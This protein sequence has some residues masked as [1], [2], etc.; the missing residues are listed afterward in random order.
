MGGATSP[1]DESF[2][3]EEKGA[4]REVLCYLEVD[5]LGGQADIQCHVR[6]FKHRLVGVAC[7]SDEGTGKVH[8]YSLKRSK[9]LSPEGIAGVWFKPDPSCR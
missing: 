9:G 7:L 2:E 1:A 8:S 5:G 4:S 3:A 6:F